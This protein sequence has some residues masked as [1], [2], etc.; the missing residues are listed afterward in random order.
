MTRTDVETI[1]TAGAAKLEYSRTQPVL[2]PYVTFP[3]PLWPVHS[4]WPDRLFP[5]C[6]LRGSMLI[7]PALQN[8]LA[9]QHS[10]PL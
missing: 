3:A 6:L 9:Q 5:R 2:S 7:S 4:L 8:F 10:P 1:A